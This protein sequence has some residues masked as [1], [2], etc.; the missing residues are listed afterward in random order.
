MMTIVS[1][2]GTAIA[3]Q[4]DTPVLVTVVVPVLHD[5][6]A[7]A[8][9]L[10]RQWPHVSSAEQWVVVNGDAGDAAMADVRERFPHVEWVETAAGRGP[11]QNAGA[12]VALGR[13]L[14]FLHADT[15]LPPGWRDDVT[16]L[17]ALASKEWGCFRLGI[18][19]RAWQARVLERIVSA[20][21]RLLSLPYGDQG[22][23][24]RRDVFVA[25]GGF[26]AYPLMEDVALVRMLARRGRPWVSHK[27]V[28]TSAR[29]WERD[30]WLRRSAR[31]VW[32]LTRYLLGTPPERLVASYQ[33]KAGPR[34]RWGWFHRDRR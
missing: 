17:D 27:A 4:C 9:L 22:L 11:Q 32:L 29:R 14:L 31:N 21:L 2:S 30:G 8:D 26:P 6:P 34:R 23:L 20:R 15:Q 1:G 13:W 25:V 18:D 7:L 16:Q 3:G 28:Q 24:V 19:A 33:G 12:A 10:G 5:A